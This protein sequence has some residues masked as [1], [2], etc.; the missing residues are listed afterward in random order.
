MNEF[1]KKKLS[2]RCQESSNIMRKYPEKIPVL[3]FPASSNKTLPK[4][5]KNKFLVSK[6]L[7]VGQFLYIIRKRVHLDSSKALFMFTE[8][9]TIPVT[10]DSISTIY[11]TY[12]NEDGF[13]YFKISSENT[14]G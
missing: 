6:D 10:H 1:K 7:T 9:D 4:L 13:L 14:F 5:D 11:H 8:K 2:E 3:V 12:K